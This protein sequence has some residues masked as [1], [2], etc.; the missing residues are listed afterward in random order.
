MIRRSL[1]NLADL[2]LSGPSMSLLA[3]AIVCGGCQ[4]PK[5]PEIFGALPGGTAAPETPLFLR[6][7]AS[8]LLTN[9]AGFSAR[10]LLEIRPV[11][12]EVQ[13]VSGELLGHGPKL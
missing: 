7:P 12:N 5:P 13:V 9:T 6:G 4:S 2:F 3:G 10:V 8:L 11:P 1:R